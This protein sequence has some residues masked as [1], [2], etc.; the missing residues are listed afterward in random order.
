MPLTPSQPELLGRD[1]TR[2]PA[3]R[4]LPGAVGV[5]SW[6]QVGGSGRV[7]LW[8]GREMTGRVCMLGSRG[9]RGAACLAQ[10]SPHRAPHSRGATPV[11]SFLTLGSC[12][13]SPAAFT[14]P[15][16]AAWVRSSTD[17][18]TNQAQEG[19][20]PAWLLALRGSLTQT[21]GSLPKPLYS[22]SPQTPCRR[23]GPKS[24]YLR[25]GAK[26]RLPCIPAGD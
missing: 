8:S 23:S 16:T 12:P 11:N 18:W 6:G 4:K 10:P 25:A 15:A 7:S 26:S 22:F 5:G 17:K 1:H 19:R 2:R 20:D 13:R 21:P 24:Q 9:E 3:T 14:L